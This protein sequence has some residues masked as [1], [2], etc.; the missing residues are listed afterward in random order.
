MTLG[1]ALRAWWAVLLAGPQPPA[2]PAPPLQCQFQA[3]EPLTAAM[4]V[5]PLVPV[6]LMDAHERV[7]VREASIPSV[8]RQP[9]LV[10]DGHEYVMARQD[11][12]TWIYRQQ[13]A[14]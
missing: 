11:G 4:L 5:D 10:Y 2:V 14:R 8:R 7:V 13:E 3:A 12:P 9:C 6:R 1:Q